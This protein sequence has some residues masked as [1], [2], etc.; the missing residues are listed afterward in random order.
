M[1]R[2]QTTHRIALLFNANKVYDR[3][4]IAG[5]GHYLQS[6]RV[7]WDLFLE[8]DFRWPLETASN[9]GTA[10]ASLPTS[11][12]RPFVLRCI[13]VKCRWW[14]SALPIAMPLLYPVNLPYIAT[15]NAKLMEL[16]YGHLI[17]VGLQQIR[18]VQPAGGPENRW[19]Q[20]RE[21]AFQ[22]LLD[23]DA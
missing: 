18:G 13:N 11:T 15:D 9:N 12:I 22:S 16:A 20:E 7:V 10:T 19:A 17:D 4:I 8:E 1:S 3:E 5:I 23:A 21:A 2:T 6:T 14:R